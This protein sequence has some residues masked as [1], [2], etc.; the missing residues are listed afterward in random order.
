MADGQF[1]L[2]SNICI[3]LLR[4]LSPILASR[5]ATQAEETLFVSSVSLA[6]IA[7]GYGAAV[8]DSPDLVGFLKEVPPVAFNERAAMIY[9]TLPFRRARFDRLIAAHA[10]ALDMVLV[11]NN[12]ADFADIADLKI[13][14]W[15]L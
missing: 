1:L 3:Y 13:E 8:F 15:T 6:E 10:V 12:E 9:G 2:D 4:D 14:N 7:V 5:V 11:T